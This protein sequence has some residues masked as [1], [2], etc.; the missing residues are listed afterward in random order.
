MTVLQGLHH[1]PPM[2]VFAFALATPATVIPPFVAEGV[3]ATRRCAA[4]KTDL[5]PLR[6]LNLLAMVDALN[7]LP[8]VQAHAV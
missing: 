3:S 4:L 6:L 8:R 2:L 7:W 5:L 1:W